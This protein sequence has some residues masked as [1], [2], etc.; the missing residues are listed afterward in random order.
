MYIKL[1][2]HT[3]TGF[4]KAWVVAETAASI[5]KST[6]SDTER[7]VHA[8][9]ERLGIAFNIVFWP[10]TLDDVALSEIP[11]T[12]FVSAAFNTAAA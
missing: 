6:K 7:K 10:K 1:G 8:R 5:D 2:E 12:S 9:N 11:S 3:K 4:F